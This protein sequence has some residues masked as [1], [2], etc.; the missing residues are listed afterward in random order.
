MRSG[1]ALSVR[2]GTAFAVGPSSPHFAFA[3]L[4]RV[5]KRRPYYL[6]T[7]F[8]RIHSRSPFRPS[9]R[10]TKCVGCISILGLLSRFTPRRCQR[11][12]GKVATELNTTH[13]P[14]GHSFHATF[15]SYRLPIGHP[16]VFLVAGDLACEPQHQDVDPAMGFAGGAA[17]RESRGCFRARA[18]LLMRWQVSLM[19]CIAAS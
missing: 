10:P 4:G 2:R 1:R 14:M 17:E 15:R 7:R 6:T 12:M 11:R 9:P 8:R 19:L 18:R 13:G 5:N 16:G 3:Q